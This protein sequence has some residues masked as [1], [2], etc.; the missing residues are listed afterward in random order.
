[1]E[2]ADIAAGLF[3]S[4]AAFLASGTMA[5]AYIQFHWKFAFDSGFFPVVNKGELAALYCFLFLFMAGEFHCELE[6]VPI[7]Q[8][9]IAPA[10]ETMRRLVDEMG[11][12]LVTDVREF[13]LDRPDPLGR[14]GIL[15]LGEGL[16]LDL[17]LTAPPLERVPARA[18]HDLAREVAPELGHDHPGMHGERPHALLR[19]PTVELDCEQDVGGLRLPVRGPLLVRVALEPDVV[20]ADR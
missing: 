15:L 5:V 3:A 19:Q 11:I 1:M 7:D 20:E 12:E 13:L 8:F 4:W 17:Y 2:Y 6:P 10:M 16:L 18:L 9:V 14:G